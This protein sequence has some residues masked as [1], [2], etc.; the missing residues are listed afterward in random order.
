MPPH[1]LPRPLAHPLGAQVRVDDLLQLRHQA[2]GLD[3]RA[4]KRVMNLMAGGYLSGFRGRGMEFLETRH[5]L[6]GDDIRAMDWR[7]TARSG[8]PHTKVFQEERERPVLVMVDL[9]PGMYFGTRAAFKAVAAIQAAVLL[10]WAA[11]GQGDRVGGL[12]FDTHQRREIR[13]EARQK[14]VL[15][16]IHTLVEGHNQA[17]ARP[18]SAMPNA[19]LAEALEHARRLCHPGTLLCLFSDFAGFD[20]ASAKLTR[21]LGGHADVLAGLVYDEIERELPPPGVYPISDG[22]HARWLDTR[23][24]KLRAAH[25]Q[26]FAAHRQRVEKAFLAKGLHL[27]PL[28]TH[29][30]PAQALRTSGWGRNAPRANTASTQ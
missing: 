4:R 26:H 28:A 23:D 20:D 2:V 25:R 12:W 8:Q 24:A 5:Y 15:R 10:A 18:A 11:A 1:T 30:D 16:L 6:P 14:G 21:Q 13:P 27:F 17:M 29:D 22:S 7:V 19:G 9:R 3:V